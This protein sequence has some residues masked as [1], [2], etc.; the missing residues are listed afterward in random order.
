MIYSLVEY[1][2]T[3]KEKI[4]QSLKF[5]V[6]ICLLSGCDMFA[7]QKPM[8]VI[9]ERIDATGLSVK[10]GIPSK[11]IISLSSG[12][13]E[14]LYVL[15]KGDDIIA[16]TDDCSYM[17]QVKG[18]DRV[19]DRSNISIEKLIRLSPELVLSVDGDIPEQTITN[20]RDIGITVFVLK[21]CVTSEDIQENFRFLGMITG[22]QNVVEL[23]IAD[24]NKKI[25][26]VAERIK[27]NPI[28]RV[29]LEVS[30]KPLTTVGADSFANT[31]ISLSGGE[32]I[33]RGKTKFPFYSVPAVIKN[34]PDVII[35]SNVPDEE[36]LRWKQIESLIASQNNRIYSIDPNLINFST[37][38]AL[39]E[40]VEK[41]SMLLYPIAGASPH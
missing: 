25:K 37:P 34:N 18:K 23:N 27:G 20:L 31:I 10:I 12:I 22:K 36:K 26:G 17:P 9:Q 6:L 15:E 2:C 8:D 41:V 13:T 7:P 33:V 35:L 28:P 3:K 5:I 38:L 16:V 30:A 32:N 19:G 11:K 4:M 24:A 14:G 39:A 21:K 40:A 1:I 29:F